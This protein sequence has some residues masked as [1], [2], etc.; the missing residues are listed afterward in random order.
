MLLT[1]DF[2]F[3]S[4]L[5]LKL[6]SKF[7]EDCHVD[8][9]EL[10]SFKEDEHLESVS[11]SELEKRLNKSFDLDLDFLQSITKT[12]FKQA[13]LVKLAHFAISI[14]NEQSK[15]VNSSSKKAKK[16]K[17]DEPT[18]SFYRLRFVSIAHVDNCLFLMRKPLK[19]RKGNII[20]FGKIEKMYFDKTIKIEMNSG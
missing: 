3:S 12:K 11:I 1:Q 9:D 5:V 4:D 10:N 20:D 2:K 14:A 18:V 6:I 13:D 19:E 15:S 7:Q 16:R 8:E 17:A